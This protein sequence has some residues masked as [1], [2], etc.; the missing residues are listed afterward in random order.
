MVVEGGA[1]GCIAVIGNK[2]SSDGGVRG[3]YKWVVVI[4]TKN[5]VSN[6]IDSK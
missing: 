2:G 1:G 6:M 4:W 3:W 5:K